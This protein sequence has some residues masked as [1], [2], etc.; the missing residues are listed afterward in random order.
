LEISVLKFGGT[1]VGNSFAIKQA[2]SRVI[3]SKSD[4][5]IVVLSAMSKVT[6]ELIKIANLSI[7][8]IN[9]AIV[10]LENLKN[11]HIS[12]LED[13]VPN[14][15][16]GIKSKI[17]QYFFELENLS[18]G[19]NYLEE[20]TNKI[21]DKFISY[22]EL[23]STEIFNTYIKYVGYSSEL[24]LSTNYII[25]DS[26][27]NQAIPIFDEIDKRFVN[28]NFDF[29]IIIFQ[30]FIGSNLIG[31]TTTLG[32]GGSDFTASI[33]GSALKNNLS[34]IKEIVIYTDVDG[35]L[36]CDPRT[37]IN[38]SL[39]PEISYQEVLELSFFGA[40]VLHPDT[41]KPAIDNGIPVIVRNTFKPEISGTLIN[42]NLNNK[43]TIVVD[44]LDVLFIKLYSK[45]SV[46]TKEELKNIFNLVQ[47]FS[48]KIYYQSFS[49]NK[50]Q[51]LIKNDNSIFFDYLEDNILFKIYKCSAKAYIK[52]N[53]YLNKNNN[54]ILSGYSPNS[55]IEIISL[56]ETN[57]FN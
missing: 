9:Q 43:D 54:L 51:I 52:N 48:S 14:N 41:I 40:K 27:F 55:Y 26:T 20:L 31:E 1:S 44:L 50:F 21:L 57:M 29:P 16:Q 18:K 13:L 17:N 12:T 4:V 19:I 38:F 28:F 23:L 45:N 53:I 35:I 39:I 47:N 11:R 22:G 42:N 5:K 3:E 24:K 2:A 8:N 33:I 15:N 10:K 36:N 6:D 37:N 49:L 32:R 30:G 7:N 56:E 25:T 34:N 46:F